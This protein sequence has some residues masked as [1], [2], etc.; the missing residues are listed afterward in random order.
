MGRV[1]TVAVLAAAGVLAFAAGAGAAWI[2]TGD[3]P[4]REGVGPGPWTT[5]T[6][7]V[8]DASAGLLQRAVIARVGLWALPRS[9]VIYYRAEADDEGRP[10]SRRCVYAIEGKV[11][12]PTRWWSIALYRDHFWVDNPLDRYSFSKTTVARAQDGS[13]T[14]L[15][16]EKPQSGNWLPMGSA[17]GRF[18]LPFRMYQP[19]PSVGRDPENVP[20][21]SVRRVSCA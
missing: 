3:P 1:G 5:S 7:G 21:P 6:Q 4:Q 17:D 10:L 14:I 2:Y 16:S 15:L 12:P 18:T 19:E 8:G 13:W 20:M 11:D 9:E